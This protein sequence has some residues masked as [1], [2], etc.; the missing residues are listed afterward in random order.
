VTPAA[1]QEHRLAIMTNWSFFAS[2]GF[3]LALSGFSESNPFAGVAGFGAFTTAFIGHVVINRIFRADF[4]NAQIALGLTAF[5]AA[6]VVFVASCVFDP[7]FGEINVGVGLVGFTTL[8]ACFI[9]Y[10]MINYGVRGS[11]AMMHRL[12]RQERR[13]Q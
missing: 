7:H 5:T 1:Q 12:H 6:V 2:F 10:V 11:Y 8:M 9:V 4:T 3:C 13:G